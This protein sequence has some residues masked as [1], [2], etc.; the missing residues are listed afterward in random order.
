M[1]LRLHNRAKAEIQEAAIR[2]RT[3]AEGLDFKFLAA[4]HESLERIEVE[5]SRFARLETLGE[6]TTFRRAL[7][8]GFPYLVVYESFDKE[9]FVYA[10][11][12]ASR[13]PNYWKRRRRNSN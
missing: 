13:R 2:Y 7:V 10:V 3:R 8:K 11:A 6:G 5:P 12:H 4:I 9:V 1:I